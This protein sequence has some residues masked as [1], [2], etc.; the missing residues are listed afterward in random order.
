MR[1]IIKRACLSTEVIVTFDDGHT[2]TAWFN[3][4]KFA[5]VSDVASPRGDSVYDRKHHALVE[6]LIAQ[7][8]FEKIS[9][10][11]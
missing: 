7:A 4:G 10:V 9:V 3:N 2:V 5:F 1:K 8:G 6:R 11:S